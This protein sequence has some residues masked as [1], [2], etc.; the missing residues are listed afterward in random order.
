MGDDD[1]EEGVSAESGATN[2]R[3]GGRVAEE[4]QEGS[5]AEAREDEDLEEGRGSKGATGVGKWKIEP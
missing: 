5:T 2:A 1:E 4:K 3:I